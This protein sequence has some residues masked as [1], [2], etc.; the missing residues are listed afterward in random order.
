MI[1]QLA[2]IFDRIDR[3]GEHLDTIKCGLLR[4][5]EADEYRLSGEYQRNPDGRG[6]TISTDPVT[7]PKVDSRLNT[8]IG[9]HLHDLRSSLDHLAWQLVLEAKGTPT[10]KTRFPVRDTDPGTNKKGEPRTPGVSGGVS[11]RAL[12]LIREAQPYQFGARHAEHPLWLLQQLWNIDKHR[13]VIAKGSFGRYVFPWSAPT[14][15]FTSR[16]S[17][18]SPYE[19][20]L[21]LEPD[22]PN[23]SVEAEGFVDVAIYEPAYGI[24]RPLLP[25]LEEATGA[26]RQVVESAEETCF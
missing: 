24:E 10:D 22:D 8:T 1:E 17:S 7:L 16:L 6:G 13:Y 25:T 12:A 4:H 14:F 3:A 5:Y 20:K 2:A 26:V 15:R 21:A 23:V 18:A 11:S 19:A 9:E